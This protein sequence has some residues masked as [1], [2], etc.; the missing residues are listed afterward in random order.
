ME[1]LM[2]D[3]NQITVRKAVA[4]DMDYI[5]H[6]NQQIEGD[7]AKLT[8]EVLKRDVFCQNPKAFAV[9]AEISGKPVG[10]AF[11]AFTYWASEGSILWVSQ[12]YIEAEFRGG[13]TVY[14][15]RDGLTEQ[16]E[17]EG[18][19]FMVWATHSTADRSNKLWKR[20]GAKDLSENYS[21]WVR[22]I[23]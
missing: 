11:Y 18:A 2:D 17:K 9:L 6:A 15:L 10:M 23:D 5:V 22:S 3:S 12:M 14:A 21:F 19:G 7:R 20:I 16:S 8:A 4:S 1:E 13:Q